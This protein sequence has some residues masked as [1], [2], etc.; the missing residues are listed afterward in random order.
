MEL[1]KIVEEQKL[2]DWIKLAQGRCLYHLRNEVDSQDISQSV[3]I[4][5]LLNLAKIKV[6]EAWI[7]SVARNK[8]Y[9]FMRRNA[10]Y[11]SMLSKLEIESKL[12]SSI[13]LQNL[14][15]NDKI[16]LEKLITGIPHDQIT[17]KDLDM[18][19]E[20]INCGSDL[21]ALQK[22]FPL[23]P[24][25][26]RKRIYTIKRDITAWI[27][28]QRG[29]TC[30]KKLIVGEHLHRNILHFTSK[31]KEC[32]LSRN[33]QPIR[34]YL[35]PDIEIPEDFSIPVY[36]TQ[37]FD[38]IYKQND[39]FLIKVIYFSKDIKASGYSFIIKIVKP[40]GIQ[41]IRFP[42][43]VSK[44][45]STPYKDL[46]QEIRDAVKPLPNGTLKL[47]QKDLLA[48]FKKYNIKPKVL[49]SANKSQN[50]S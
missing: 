1:S 2:P 21:N 23:K 28:R 14:T 38:V 41:V 29:V 33:W 48:L 30:G 11:S 50:E 7:I 4:E 36:E 39:E 6:P 24:E 49:F 34:K 40:H 35:A 42:Q 16:S 17:S 9:D 44:I 18:F 37:K 3:I 25:T 22:I 8:C 47:A 5:L 20:Y 31:F 43:P 15:D 10:A 46:P 32:L 13:K 27:N 12:A 45:I 19:M 26:L